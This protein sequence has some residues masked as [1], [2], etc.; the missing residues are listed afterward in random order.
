LTGKE[1]KASIDGAKSKADEKLQT[2]MT[3]DQWKKWT[4]FKEEQKKNHQDKKAA[5]QPTTNPTNT[6]EKEDF[7]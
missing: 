5:A 4:S 2:V 3:P 1:K 6:T 7:Y